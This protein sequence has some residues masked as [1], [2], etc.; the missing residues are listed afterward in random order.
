MSQHHY[1][2]GELVSPG[3]PGGL[4]SVTTILD[5]RANPGLVA[6]R[7]RV[8][9]E[10]ADKKRDDSQVL[11]T[12]IHLEIERFILGEPPL[13][14]T[15]NWAIEAFKAWCEKTGFIP[16]VA[17]LYIESSHGYA[18]RLD[19]LGEMDD[20]L[21][22][23]D[24]KSGKIQPSHGL[25]LAAYA[26]AVAEDLD[27]DVVPRRGVLQLTQDLKRG[28]RFKEFTDVDGEP[29]DFEVFMAHKKIY[30][31]YIKHNPIPEPIVW[32]GGVIHAPETKA[33]T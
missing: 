2:D 27:L 3:T 29:A 15:L 20:D 13:D 18:G 17:E 21:W 30:D 12:A 31:W 7:E 26:E 16:Q 32:D 6:W 8:G 11:G 14:Y 22:I 33:L 5:V 9:D 23:I 10:A 19:I 28:Y 24:L 4:P 25:Q 1:L